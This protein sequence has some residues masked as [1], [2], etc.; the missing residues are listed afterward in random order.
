MIA[1]AKFMHNPMKFGSVTD[2]ILTAPNSTT[3]SNARDSAR[4][5][6]SRA[7]HQKLGDIFSRDETHQ[8]ATVRNR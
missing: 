3:I 7:Y 5:S 8:P 2:Q 4:R 6:Q 1:W